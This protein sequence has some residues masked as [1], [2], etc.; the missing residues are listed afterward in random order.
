VQRESAPSNEVNKMPIYNYQC[1]ECKHEFEILRTME[2][3][4][5]P[6]E[7]PKCKEESVRSVSSVAPAQFKGK[8]WTPKRMERR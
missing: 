2:H 1:K 6:L 7:C 3:R 4:D 5:R 8:G